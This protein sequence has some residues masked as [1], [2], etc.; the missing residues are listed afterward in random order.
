MQEDAKRE[1]KP[2]KVGDAPFWEKNDVMV[3]FT[4]MQI[5]ILH[6]MPWK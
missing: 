6:Q 1:T 2:M 3:R 5:W 4:L